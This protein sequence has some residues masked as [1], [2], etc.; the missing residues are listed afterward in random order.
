M[1]RNVEGLLRALVDLKEI[2]DRLP[3]VFHGI[4]LNPNAGENYISPFGWSRWAKFTF[5]LSKRCPA[6]SGLQM[7]PFLLMDA[8]LGRRKYDSFLGVEGLH[9]RAWLPANHRAF[10]AAIESHYSIP[11]FVKASGDQR[12]M[13]V[14]EGIVE[15]YTGEVSFLQKTPRRHSYI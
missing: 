7:P 6:I 2:I 11:D 5:P 13:G 14:L 8:F 10:I 4:S 3:G 1:T 15:S 12:L 9:L